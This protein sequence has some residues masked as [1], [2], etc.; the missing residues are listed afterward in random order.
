MP[1][2]KPALD[3]TTLEPRRG[4]N[5]PA[6]F[7][8]LVEGREKRVLGDAVGLTNF[9]VNLVTMAPGAASALRHWHAKEDEFIFVLE[10]EVTLVTDSGEQ[11]LTAGQCAGFPANRADGHHLLNKSQSVARYLEVGDRQAGE[12]VVYSDVDLATHKG[13]DG[14]WV[15]TYK[16]GRPYGQST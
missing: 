7:R 5:Y 9:G 12:K 10:G 13:A 2:T 15:F 11:R 3:P 6:A 16:D 14:K 4:T 1:L 8:S